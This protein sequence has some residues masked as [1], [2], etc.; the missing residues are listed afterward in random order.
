MLGACYPMTDKKTLQ[1]LLAL[2]LFAALAMYLMILFLNGGNFTYSLDDPYIHMTLARNIL[3]GHYGIQPGEYSS[4]SSSILWPFILTV[5]SK[6]SFFLFLPWFLNLCFALLQIICFYKTVTELILPGKRISSAALFLLIAML[7]VAS[8]SLGLLFT[9]MEHSLQVLLI[10]Y[11]V[12]EFLK[13]TEGGELG[14]WVWIIVIASP[15]I[16]YENLGMSLLFVLLLFHRRNYYKAILLGVCIAVPLVVFSF[17]LHSLELPLL[18]LSILK[19]SNVFQDR[20][21]IGNI[22]GNFLSGFRSTYGRFLLPFYFLYAILFALKLRNAE[23]KLSVVA[24]AGLFLILFHFAGGKFGGFGRYEVYCGV[25]VQLLLLYLYRDFIAGALTAFKLRH[26]VAAMLILINLLPYLGTAYATPRAAHN[27]Y[28]EQF[29]MARFVRQFC[30]V[31]AAANDIGLVTYENKNYVLDLVGL[32]NKETQDL[33]T[34]STGV[35]LQTL[36]AK[37]NIK[38][39]MIYKEWFPAIPGSWTELGTMRIGGKIIF[40]GPKVVFYAVNKQEVE[41]FENAL[42]SFSATLPTGTGFEFAK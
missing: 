32:A 13:M 3:S 40:I 30:P 24:L 2:Y 37:Y 5:F 33:M 29:Q 25:A 21:F 4:P 26:G 18:P 36:I 15:L 20:S 7:T 11:L 17:F 42:K 34:D 22:P 19:K 10:V 41:L 12:Y 38:L 31:T 16:R 35:K 39:V 28:Q 6:A 8:N 9:G 1:L 23:R 27:I 14:V